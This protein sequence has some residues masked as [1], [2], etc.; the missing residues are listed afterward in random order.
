M[1]TS[2]APSVR[3]EPLRPACE[4]CVLRSALAELLAPGRQHAAADHAQDEGESRKIAVVPRERG[5]QTWRRCQN[6]DVHG[7][8]PR[9]MWV[10][11]NI[12]GTSSGSL[13][14]AT[15]SR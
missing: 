14:M 7:K 10:E 6:F 1:A 8:I 2:V 5:E 9:A 15:L 11:H 12:V 4:A 13:R 3:V